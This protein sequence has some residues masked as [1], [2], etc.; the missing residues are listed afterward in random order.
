MDSTDTARNHL[1]GSSHTSLNT[2]LE[3]TPN[4]SPELCHSDSHTAAA[5]QHDIDTTP[6]QDIST[7][8]QTMLKDTSPVASVSAQTESNSAAAGSRPIIT[9]PPPPWS[10]LT[11]SPSPSPP[12][13]AIT[14]TRATSSSATLSQDSQVEQ[15]K[16]DLMMHTQ[17]Q[18]QVY[19]EDLE[20]A[21]AEAHVQAAIEASLHGGDP[22]D[23]LSSTS[24]S[25]SYGTAATATTLFG[26]AGLSSTSAPVVQEVTAESFQQ[27]MLSLESTALAAVASATSSSA[28]GQ[29]APSQGR[30]EGDLH[31]LQEGEEGEMDDD[32]EECLPPSET[33]YILYDDHVSPVSIAQALVILNGDLYEDY[34]GPEAMSTDDHRRNNSH[35][36]FDRD[37]NSVL[38][39]GFPSSRA[40]LTSFVGGAPTDEDELLDD[41]SE[42]SPIRRDFHGL[43][44][45]DDG[46]T[47]YGN[48]KGLHPDYANSRDIGYGHYSSLTGMLSPPTASK[49]DFI[50]T[51][52]CD[53]ENLQGRPGFWSGPDISLNLAG[54]VVSP[55]A[56]HDLFFSRYYS[57]LVYL[58]LWDT[59][60]GTWGAQAVGG[61]M[62]DR[63]CRVEYLN[64]GCNRLGFEGIVQ[65]WG[66]YKNSSLVELDLSENQL[67]PKAVHTLQ[68]IMVRLQKNKACNIRR[69]NLSNNVINDVGC[70][71]IAKIILGSI[72]THLDLSF[73]KI[74]DWGASTILAAFESNDLTLRDINMEANPM[75]YAGGVDICKIL[76]LPQSRI[77]HLDLRGAKVTDVG[78]PYLAEALK[79]HSCPVVSLNL[80]D[81]QLTDTGILKLAIKLSVNKSLRVLGLGCNC[82][83]DMGILALSQGLMLN[84]YLEELDLSEND[85]AISRA[86]MEAL[87]SVMRSN[88]SLL[89]LRV[90]VDGHPHAV[91]RSSA[92]SW[93]PGFE[94]GTE[95][96][97]Q[98]LPHHQQRQQ[99]QQQPQ[100]IANSGEMLANTNSYGF[101]VSNGAQVGEVLAPTHAA[102]AQP[103]LVPAL[104]TPPSVQNQAHMQP[105]LPP[106]AFFGQAGLGAPVL[107]EQQLEQERKQLNL[108]L[109]TLKTYVRHNYKRTGRMRRLCFEILAIAR[110][111]L[112]AK[113]APMFVPSE[114]RPSNYPSSPLSA[115]PF[116]SSS[117]S[118]ATLDHTKFSGQTLPRSDPDVVG[119]LQELSLGLK[120]G[121]PP[122]V[123]PMQTGLPTP[124]LAM[125]ADL[126]L[127]ARL[128]LT[129]E[130][131]TL[132]STGD[133]TMLE[134]GE[135]SPA[136]RATLAC[137]PWEIKEMILRALDTQ[138]LLSGK[139]F[140]AIMKYS[141]SQWETTRQPWERW[142]EIREMILEKTLCY[143]YEP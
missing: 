36:H 49:S 129:M 43:E 20:E 108:A 110:V 25:A 8:T 27:Q 69:L 139:Q 84:N 61:L 31:D 9:L 74:S 87:I 124:P 28:A 29:G 67:G 22:L 32:D 57:R 133:K 114:S 115:S 94:S 120:G 119:R 79:S 33:K 95:Y 63:A 143:Y 60:L 54:N 26:T 15:Y 117:A 96:Q 127:K 89:D 35:S 16:D 128:S 34:A 14:D 132:D 109:T 66:T 101:M 62:A 122:S 53:D 55:I 112:F 106:L 65:L 23:P 93:F 111:L 51:E 140:Q 113:D 19:L 41:D 68:Q 99:Q 103:L 125:D 1:P 2:V 98:Q 70:I 92:G 59:N 138:G 4:I 102:L 107:N 77:T 21:E 72:L 100:T 56:I 81:C 131:S 10:A 44:S 52:S 71:S 17:L 47:L 6:L 24:L 73:N 141:G 37:G 46:E 116:L 134:S 83:G 39:S 50:S 123:I 75:S 40:H 82:I 136:P 91:T 48:G 105:G 76:A 85:M 126:V 38:Y 121:S 3:T 80:Y 135:R 130:K 78:V 18:L 118:P 13:N 7:A 97:H 11:T 42:S 88:T 30:V 45:G 137:L 64:L 58:N 90:D 5:L 104:A 86:G 12:T 142:G